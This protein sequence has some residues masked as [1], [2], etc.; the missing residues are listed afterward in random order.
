MR[1][2]VVLRPEPGAA[3]TATRAA[4]IGLAAI[5]APLFE[6]RPIAWDAPDPAAFDALMLTSANAVRHAGGDLARYQT[7]P[8]YVVGA[9]TARAARDA[10]FTDIHV[11]GG[12]AAALARLMAAEGVGRALHLAGRDHRDIREPALHVTRRL[13]YASEPVA[14]L[15]AEAAEALRRGSV[16]LIHSPR[17]ATIL[18]QLLDTA[19]IAPGTIPIAAISPA[20]ADAAGSIWAATAVAATPDDA[21]L[22]AAAAR[23]CE[24]HGQTPAGSSATR[25]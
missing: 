20:S 13:V 21:A 11:G 6:V 17:A 23:L 5:V 12:D 16:A 10:G 1:G 7:M 14:T 8:A 25:M 22:L 19:A 2:L 24:E 4:A 15:S 3:A 9:A 18:R